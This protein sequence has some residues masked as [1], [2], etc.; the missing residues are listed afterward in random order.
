MI[1]ACLGLIIGFIESRKLY[2]FRYFTFVLLL[3]AGVVLFDHYEKSR[4]KEVV[5]YDVQG[6]SY[7]DVFL[8]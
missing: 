6:N 1:I 3:I 8:G 7:V 4:Q 5:F 2:L